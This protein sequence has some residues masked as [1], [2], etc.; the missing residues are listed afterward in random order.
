MYQ[1]RYIT[2][3]GKWAS[4]AFFLLG[5]SGTTA[6]WITYITLCGLMRF[7]KSHPG[8]AAV[9]VDEFDIGQLQGPPNRQIVS[10]RHGGL[11][12]G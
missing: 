4:I 10:G 7:L 2:A 1:K 11:A 3:R 5:N 8:A 6:F 9:L 12:V